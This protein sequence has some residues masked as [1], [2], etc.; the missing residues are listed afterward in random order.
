MCAQAAQIFSPRQSCLIFFCLYQARENVGYVVA[1]VRSLQN[2][3]SDLSKDL[4][5]RLDSILEAAVVLD[6]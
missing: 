6:K 5:A 4:D 1:E 2:E 3:M